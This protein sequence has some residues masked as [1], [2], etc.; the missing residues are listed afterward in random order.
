MTLSCAF[1][2]NT[3]S[4]YMIIHTTILL[5]V[6]GEKKSQS[7]QPIYLWAQIRSLSS[8]YSGSKPNW[9]KTAFRIVT[10][11][12][13]EGE[14]KPATAVTEY[15]PLCFLK[16]PDESEQR[17]NKHW[18]WRLSP[19]ARALSCWCRGSAWGS[20]TLHRASPPDG[21]ERGKEKTSVW[22]QQKFQYKRKATVTRWKMDPFN[23]GSGLQNVQSFPWAWT[24]IYWNKK[25]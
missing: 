23:L 4:F 15:K 16:E 14:S 13:T 3:F 17:R 12:Y 7:K 25:E 21:R 18:R 1:G 24:G 2:L 10:W 11:S 19:V 9:H 20:S 8:F 5:D 6:W 22:N